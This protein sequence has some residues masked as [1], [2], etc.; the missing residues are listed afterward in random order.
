M[1]RE[2]NIE[3]YIP[4]GPVLSQLDPRW[5]YIL[6][7]VQVHTT[8][9]CMSYREQLGPDLVLPTFYCSS[10]HNYTLHVLHRTIGPRSRVT[11]FLLFKYT[12]PHT[13]F[14]REQLGPDL[15]L[16]TFY[17]SSTHNHTM[18]V[19]QRT[20]RHRTFQGRPCIP[21]QFLINFKY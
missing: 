4:P 2:L 6:S 18:H 1:L 13:M 17:C 19:L 15:V 14:Y 12:Q 10:R 11:Y 3:G 20:I 8:T 7:T 16:P 9:H 5:S 21:R